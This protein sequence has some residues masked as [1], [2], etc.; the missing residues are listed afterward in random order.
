MNLEHQVSELFRQRMEDFAKWAAENWTVTELEAERD[1]I[2]D[3]KPPG[4]REGYNAA[5]TELGGMFPIRDHNPS[6][7]TPYVTY[8]LMAANIGIF[9]SHFNLMQ[10]AA[11]INA[12]YATP[13]GQKVISTVPQLVAERNRLA[14]QR[15]QDNRE[16]LR[17]ILAGDA[18][19]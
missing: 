16:Q 10:D 15:L 2:F 11:A 4:Y 19:P 8:L 17:G 5:I 3:T 6:G 14:M 1:N 12:F 18:S 7:R 13:A 9:L